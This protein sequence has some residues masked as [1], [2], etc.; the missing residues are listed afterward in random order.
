MPYIAPRNISAPKSPKVNF[1]P[2]NKL[3]GG[4]DLFD[5]EWKIGADK[6]SKTLNM[7]FYQ[8][9]LLKRWGQAYLSS[10]ISTWN[11]TVVWNDALTW[12]D[13]LTWIDDLSET[14]Y[15]SY[16]YLYDGFIIKHC[17]TNL[18]KQ[19]PTTGTSYI[20]Y[21]GLTAVK[22]GFFKFNSNL[23]YVQSGHF[24]SWDGT[25]AAE[26]VPY[27]PLVIIN[28]T[29][30]GG[31]DLNE[32]YNRIGAG[33]KNSFNGDNSAVAYTLTDTDLDATLVT[34]TVGGVAKAE[35]TDFT[36][37]RATGIV[38]FTIAPATGTNNVVITAYKT[39]TTA[40]NSILDCL[41]A[42]PFGGQNDSRV[43]VGGNGTGYYYW[44]GI[45]SVGVDATYWAYNNYNI[46]GNSDENITGFG[47]QYDTLCIFKE[48]EI[49]G[50]SYY[51]NGTIGIFNSFPVNSQIGCDC[52]GT[53][54]NVNNNLTWLNTLG[55][56]TL[57]GTAVESQ[58]NVFQISRNINPQLLQETNLNL[59]SSVNFDGKYW[60]CV[61]D[62]V[63]LWDYTISPYVDTGNPDKSAEL[64]SWWYFDTINAHSWISDGQSLYYVDRTT[65]ASVVFN[66]LFYDFGLGI[67]AIYR[68]PMRDFGGGVYYFD[69][70]K[71]FVDVRGDTRSSIDTTY[72]TSDDPGGIVESEVITVGTFSFD[73]FSFDNFTFGVMG[74]KTTFPLTPNEKNI[75]LFGIEFANNDAGRDMNISNIV[76]SYLIKKEKR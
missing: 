40:K 24:V 13:T 68:I 75:D 47:K 39:D 63:Y 32:G 17:G 53:I 12:V 55:I 65:N 25:T 15:A 50:E 57:Q 36:V 59:A 27:I 21:T 23:Y 26:V 44:T 2:P 14:I 1:T 8:G 66:D 34:A 41:Y 38:T 5:K 70:L 28:R 3:S 31:G 22:G 67:S 58:R 69:V 73:N 33:F 10:D 71:A 45:S 49:Y 46:I 16:K 30:T 35:T 18:Y 6:T 51:F 76:L 7:W 61:N 72:F 11:D 74:P 20:I 42:I 52:P 56:Y 43:F 54:Q 64:L 48:K 62:K 37:D 29:P 4:L 19:N 60:L 9:E